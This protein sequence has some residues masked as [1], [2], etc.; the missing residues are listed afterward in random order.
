MRTSGPQRGP[1]K[2]TQT[3]H[4][5]PPGGA[6]VRH[7][8]PHSSSQTHPTQT[9]EEPS[10]SAQWD[11]SCSRSGV[12]LTVSIKRLRTWFGSPQAQSHITTLQT[13][14][15]QEFSR[16]VLSFLRWPQRPFIYRSQR[17]SLQ[18]GEGWDAVSCQ[19]DDDY[20][21]K[22]NRVHVISCE[23][24]RWEVFSSHNLPAEGQTKTST[25]V[26]SLLHQLFSTK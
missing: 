24:Q 26:F 18:P 1:Q 11:W 19:Q 6:A 10:E 16:H 17:L 5:N 12:Q 13:F 21:Y 8:L 9:T 20:K 3:P 23:G 2:S 22:N 14:L 15:L 4:I 7:T 25:L